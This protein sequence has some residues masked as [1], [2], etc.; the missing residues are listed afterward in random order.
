MQGVSHLGVED[1]GVWFDN[2]HSAVVCLNSVE[3][4]LVVADDSRNVQSQILRVH[5][6]RNRVRN[7]LFRSCGNLHAIA[8]SGQVSDEARSGWVEVGCP[9]TASREID[10]DGFGLVVAEGEDGLSGFAVDE[11]HAEDLSRWE[12]H[13]NRDCYNRTRRWVLHMLL[14]QR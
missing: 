8:N 12:V 14:E 3:N 6:R 13:V 11:L 2:R 10:G 5:V 7:T 1:A 9:K 4:V